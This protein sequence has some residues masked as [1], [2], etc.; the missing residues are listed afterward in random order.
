MKVLE[1]LM[2]HMNYFDEVFYAMQGI[3]KDE[4]G[5]TQMDGLSYD[6]KETLNEQFDKESP[7]LTFAVFSKGNEIFQTN[8]Y[9]WLFK[10]TLPFT[11]LQIPYTIYKENVVLFSTEGLK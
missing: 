9:E 10:L 6:E 8:S 7:Q 11:E 5:T 4:F 2:D 1:S 3:P